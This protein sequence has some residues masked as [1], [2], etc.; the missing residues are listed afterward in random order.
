MVPVVKDAFSNVFRYGR[1]VFVEDLEGG[2]LLLRNADATVL[3]V[4][5]NG[6]IKYRQLGLRALQIQPD[7]RCGI[8]VECPLAKTQ[9][10]VV[11]RGF[12]VLM[13]HKA[14]VSGALHNVHG[15]RGGA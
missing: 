5:T 2:C 6:A 13:L 9:Y 7:M 3:S 15:G 12:L 11:D 8:K 4:D 1:L 10:E 14:Q